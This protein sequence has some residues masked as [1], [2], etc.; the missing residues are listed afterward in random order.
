[1]Q[2]KCIENESQRDFVTR[3]KKYFIAWLDK[4]GCA[5]TFEGV[6]EHVTA[7]RYYESQS[8]ELKVY[9]KER[10]KLSL[11]ELVKVAQDYIEAYES[12]GAQKE[13]SKFKK[14][15][16]QKPKYENRGTDKQVPIWKQP[17]NGS[18]I[19]KED[20]EDNK[21][22]SG[23]FRCGS[24]FHRFRD[25]KSQKVLPTWTDKSK[26]NKVAACQLMQSN[27]D[28]K[29]EG[30]WPMVACAD[31]NEVYLKDLNYPLRGNA[32]VGGKLVRFLRDTGSSLCILKQDLI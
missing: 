10:G 22:K 5:Q 26:N 18:K 11:T 31:Q 27:V 32:K 12:V 23:C 15:N 28:S 16:E 2:A 20:F 29:K 24:N 1:L 25:C 4:A 7:D 21:P 14:L 9:L 13:F 19:H 6:V 3:L 8:H 30:S 17:V